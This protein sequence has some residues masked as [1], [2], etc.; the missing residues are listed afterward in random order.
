[1]KLRYLLTALLLLITASAQAQFNGCSGGFCS[2]RAAG[3][4][5]PTCVHRGTGADTSSDTTR[6][7]SIDIGTASS[8]RLIIVASAVQNVASGTVTVAGTPLNMDVQGVNGGSSTLYSGLVT[9]GSGTQTV[10]IVI[11]SGFVQSSVSVWACTG[12]NSNT[13][14]QTGSGIGGITSF[15][16]N[17]TA[18]DF[19]FSAGRSNS[20]TGDYGNSTQAP[21]TAY[22]MAAG[23]Y[24]AADWITIASTNASFAV[25]PGTGLNFT[26]GAAATYR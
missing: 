22:N 21:T 15:S 10:S 26:H 11:G 3:A 24:V 12:L 8:D 23:V 13:V 16:I 1:M 17:V 25:R 4:A 19:M 5:T 14:K 20:A 2:P 9:S 7:Y 6:N 18:G